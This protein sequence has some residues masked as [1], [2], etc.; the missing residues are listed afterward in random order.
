MRADLL[1]T[2][3]ERSDRLT[4]NAD[5]SPT[6]WSL[7]KQGLR[8]IA[9]TVR[10]GMRTLETGAGVSTVLLTALGAQ[11]VSIVPNDQVVSR[12]RQFCSEHDI[13]MDGTQFVIGCSEDILPRIV[14]PEVDLFLIDGCHGFPAPFIDWYYGTLWLKVG[15]VLLIDDIHIWTGRV[16]GDFLAEEVEWEHVQT[17]DKTAVYRKTGH[18]HRIKEFMDQPFVKRSGITRESEPAV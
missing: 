6:A 1:E 4:Q 12:V 16:L 8:Y 7:G 14:L 11:H 10:P 3:V 2:I 15:G 9:Q 17:L 5:G 13:S 18:A